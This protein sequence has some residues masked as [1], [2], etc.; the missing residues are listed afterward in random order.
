MNVFA[1]ELRKQN[2]EALTP[3]VIYRA[4]QAVYDRVEGSYSVVAYVIGGGMVAFRDPHGIK[5][6]IMGERRVGV[7]VAY[8]F[9]SG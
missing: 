5:P 8:C 2:A 3:E 6:I 4:V 1:R 9:A 7:D